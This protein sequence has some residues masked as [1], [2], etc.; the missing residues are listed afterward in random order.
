M[1]NLTHT[2]IGVAVAQAGLRRRVGRGA[3]LAL[4]IASNLPDIDVLGLLVAPANA[5]LFRRMFTHSVF[6]MP[7]LAVAGAALFHRYFPHQR[8][9]VWLGLFLLGGVLHVFYD[10][11]NSFGVALLYPLNRGRFELGWI[12]IVDLALIALAAPPAIACVV[13][14]W[15]A[16]AERVA[17]VSVA[18]VGLYTAFCGVSRW[19]A[20]RAMAPFVGTARSGNAALNVFP[21]PLG[22]RRFHAVLREGTINTHYLVRPWS[23]S[24]HP[25]EIITS[26]IDSPDARRLRDTPMG[27]RLDWFFKAPVW[28]ATIID[29]RPVWL[30]Y[31]LRFRSLVFRGRTP[32]VY[33][34]DFVDGVPRFR[35]PAQLPD[36]R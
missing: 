9:R 34:F 10:L 21:E 3:T 26:D 36:R 4:V 1:D 30:A 28:T 35:G 16:H 29:G 27:R 14:P 25:E 11:A 7:L 8:F 5:F 32:F 24:A 23:G 19:K 22:P 12:F 18:L 31:D 6:G 2:L 33:A 15:R 20:E 13:K 17:R